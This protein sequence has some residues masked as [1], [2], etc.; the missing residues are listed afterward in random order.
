MGN[1]AFN[2]YLLYVASIFLNSAA[3]I[4]AL[5]VVRFDLILVCLL[6][7]L[8][9]LDKKNTPKEQRL[10]DITK[11]LLILIAYI[12]LTIP[13]VHWPG[14]VIKH[15]IPE[16]IKAAIFF[17]FTF[18]IIDTDKKLKIFMSVFIGCQLFRVLEPLY[19][20]LTTG[21]WGSAASMGA[22]DEFAYRLQGSPYDIINPN[23]LA[24]ICVALIAFLH[25][26]TK[27][28]VKAYRLLYYC[29]LPVLIYVLILTLSRSG[30]VALF[31][32]AFVIFLKSRR[33]ILVL[34]AVAIAAPLLVASLS[35]VQ[36]DRYLSIV[37]SGTKNSQTAHLRVKD[38]WADL[39]VVLQ[40]PLVG[41]GLGTSV[42]ANYNVQER[43]SPSHNLYL[44][45]AEELGVVG[46][47]IFLLF[48]KSTIFT[49]M[50]TS[51]DLRRSLPPDNYLVR[52]ADALQVWLAVNLFFTIASYGLSGY[53]WYFFAG[54]TVFLYRSIKESALVA[55]ANFSPM[56]AKVFGRD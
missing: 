40:R 14:S 19:L 7:G 26:L 46:L 20:H 50:K 12:V 49:F 39:E 29:V 56:Q 6:F 33:K 35:D 22:G 5:G 48:L 18:R 44:E 41:H 13:F 54:L 10:D 2:L 42:E 16:F 3:R 34:A 30:L 37:E 23:G 32:T 8:T 24:Y 11:A 43:G 1:L 55:Q 45:V 27:S 53:H 17:Y 4:P 51:D 31:I 9:L 36:K 21:Y 47:M 25:Y 15:G 52:L 28:S 38:M